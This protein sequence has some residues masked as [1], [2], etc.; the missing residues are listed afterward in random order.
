[1]FFN[2]DKQVWLDMKKDREELRPA[3]VVHRITELI[4]E[5]ESGKSDSMEVEKFLNGKYVKVG[6]NRAGFTAKPFRIWTQ[7]GCN[8]YSQEFREMAKAYAEDE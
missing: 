8:R 1:M 4:M 5:A 3:R 6:D 2:K 7:W